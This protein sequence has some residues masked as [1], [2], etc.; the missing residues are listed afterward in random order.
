M[1]LLLLFVFDA[2]VAYVVGCWLVLRLFVRG[3][4]V[5]M[6]YVTSCLRMLVVVWWFFVWVIFLYTGCRVKP[7][8]A[9]HPFARQKWRRTAAEARAASEA[10]GRSPI[11][12]DTSFT[13]FNSYRCFQNNIT[14]FFLSWKLKFCTQHWTPILRHISKVIENSTASILVI[15]LFIPFFKY[16]NGINSKIFFFINQTFFLGYNT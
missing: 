6:F 13:F 2:V 10:V 7:P 12:R 5:C 15:Q 1:V 3:V 4:F 9:K 14:F 16:N 11:N 8:R